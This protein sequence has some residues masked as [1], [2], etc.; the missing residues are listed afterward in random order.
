MM[1]HRD[2]WGIPT[3]AN[4]SCPSERY[5]L[6]LVNLS[7]NRWLIYWLVGLPIDISESP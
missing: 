4:F 1:L 2:F 5:F 6:Y 7:N 3:M